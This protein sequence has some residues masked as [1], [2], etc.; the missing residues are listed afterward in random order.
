MPTAAIWGAGGIANTHVEALRSNGIAVAAVVSRTKA[1]AQ[2]FAQRWGIPRWGD[3]PELL[4]APEID[5]VH[6]CTPPNLHDEMAAEALR[7]GKHVLCEKPLCFSNE[8]AWALSRL[9]ARTGRIGAVNFNIRFHTACQAAREAVQA[10]DFGRVLLIHGS[11]L[12]EFGA[13]PAPVDWRMNPQM[14]GRMHAVTE[15]GSHWMDLAQ[16]MTDCPI[17]AVSAQF[18]QFHPVR[19]VENGVMYAQDGPGR[20]AMRVDS[21]DAAVVNL[22]FADGAIGAVVLSELSQGRCNRLSLEVTGEQETLWW[23]SEQPTLLSRARRGAGVQTQVF[24]FGSGFADTFRTLIGAVYQDV[25]AGGPSP[26]PSYPTFADAAVNVA[27][28]NAVWESAHHNGA[29]VSVPTQKEA[30]Q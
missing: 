19:Y 11:Y 22:R 24:A 27:L 23:N 5:C 14:A 13:L 12:Q 15:I 29:W 4:F 10:P 28:C 1:G 25:A 8:Q 30:S 2:A 21:E 20:T 16:W 9:A 17:T 6:I 3:D 18:D 26:Q 7:R